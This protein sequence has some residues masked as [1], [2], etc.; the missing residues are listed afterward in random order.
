MFE[1]IFEKYATEK[2]FGMKLGRKLKMKG[3]IND[4]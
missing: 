2:A 1:R 4:K 3:D